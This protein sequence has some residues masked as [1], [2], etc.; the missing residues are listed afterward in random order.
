LREKWSGHT[1]LFDHWDSLSEAEKKSLGAYLES[2]PLDDVDPIF[3][4]FSTYDT[5]GEVA[6]REL[7]PIA[8][9]R[10]RAT[11]PNRAKWEATGNE[12]IRTR[13][14]GML[15]LGAGQGSRLGFPHPKGMYT[16]TLPSGRSL[17]QIQAE[18]LRRVCALAG[19]SQPA[20]D[21]PCVPWYVMTN[22]DAAESVQA[23]FEQHNYWGLDASN[24]IFIKQR[25]QVCFSP[26]GR[27]LYADKTRL[28]RAPN[29]NG[30]VY[31]ALVSEGV[32]ADMARRGVEY[33][34]VYG[35][36]N[37]LIRVLD[38]LF[39][40]FMDME[41]ADAACK[42]VPKAHAHER[43]GVLV[44]KNGRPHVVEYSEITKAEAE[45]TDPATGKLMF[46]AGNICIHGFSRSY[47]EQLARDE[48]WKAMPLHVSKRKGKVYNSKTGQMEESD[49]WKAELFV[50]DVFSRAE[51]MVALEVAREEEFS[52]IKN[53]QG[54]DSPATARQHLSQL[55]ATWIEQAGGHIVGD[56]TVQVCEISPLLSYAGEGLEAT[57]GGKQF[58]LPLRLE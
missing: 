15:L 55:H 27:M 42:V 49:V 24:V 46:S 34:F 23:Y 10:S 39:L 21:A 18:R 54:S 1:Y 28:F 13:R 36:D 31:E 16:A 58:T 41:G 5:D 17:F 9:V 56:P 43:V 35:V 20:A 50:F 37:L 40:G 3:K 22:E 26:S 4:R 51:R 47:L 48:V 52:P 8:T 44:N 12:L 29:G 14:V 7:T 45:Q 33:L 57:V 19:G 53:G 25:S 11:D 30:G 2:L 32:L 38:P 6:H